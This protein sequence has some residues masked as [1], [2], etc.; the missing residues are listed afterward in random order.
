MEKI[1]ANFISGK[2]SSNTSEAKNLFDVKRFG[3]KV[4]E[5][6]VYSLPEA[7]FLVEQKK[8]ELYDDKN[9]PLTQEEIIKKFQRLDKKINLKSTVFTD[10]RKKGH[11]VKTA[12]KFGA[13]FRVYEKGKKI[14]K[15]HSKWLVFPVSETEK[16][17]WQDFSAKTRVAHST[18]KNLLIAIVDEEES[19]SYY[20]IVWTK[21]R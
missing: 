8:M 4:N 9:K 7:I 10:L 21:I 6:I 5:K 18:K 14:D 1:K 13:E 17:T 12:L 3:E 16:L 2:V 11:I 19:I 15:S 20:E